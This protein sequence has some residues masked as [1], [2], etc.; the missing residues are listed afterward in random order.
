M[1]L[2]AVKGTR[3][4]LPDEVGIWQKVERAARDVLSLAGYQE[5]RPPIFEFT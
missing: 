4:I 5:I 3:D 2:S 1:G